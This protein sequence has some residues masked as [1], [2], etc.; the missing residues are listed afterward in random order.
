MTYSK[1][2]KCGLCGGSGLLS[3]ATCKRCDGAGYWGSYFK[4]V[5][6]GASGA[7]VVANGLASMK[8]ALAARGALF[9]GGWSGGPL[10]IQT[11]GAMA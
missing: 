8:A 3:G 9:A 2:S 1:V 10:S 6:H 7:K 5:S 11:T 4:V